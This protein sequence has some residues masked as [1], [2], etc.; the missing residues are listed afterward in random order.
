MLRDVVE[1]AKGGLKPPWLV[2]LNRQVIKF[3]KDFVE[4]SLV[5]VDGFAGAMEAFDA[6]HGKADG[7][8]GDQI[9]QIAIDL[10]FNCHSDT[11]HQNA[12][13]SFFIMK[14]SLDISI[15]TANIPG[16]ESVGIEAMFDGIS[17]TTL[18]AAFSSGSFFGKGVTGG[19]RK[20]RK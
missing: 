18:T 15:Q 17:I 20:R 19:S 12:Q 10:F 9:I 7:A 13:E 11:S 5:I 4:G 8:Q 6:A 1:A 14:F 3:L 16:G 2:F